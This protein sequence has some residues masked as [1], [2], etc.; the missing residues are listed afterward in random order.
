VTGVGGTGS[1]LRHRSTFSPRFIVTLPGMRAGITLGDDTVL[2]AAP[3]SGAD[4]DEPS[5][6]EAG[7]RE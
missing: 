1:L 6:R 7:V 3:T 2:P 4:P 5:F